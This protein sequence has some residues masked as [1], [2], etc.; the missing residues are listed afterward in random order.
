MLSAD[1]VKEVGNVRIMPIQKARA[2][3]VSISRG[4]IMAGHLN[5]A[6]L[7]NLVF[8]Q[9]VPIQRNDDFTVK[10]DHVIMNTDTCTHQSTYALHHLPHFTLLP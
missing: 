10:V 5:V 9:G 1:S 8:L 4:T 3:I 7:L 6:D 2:L